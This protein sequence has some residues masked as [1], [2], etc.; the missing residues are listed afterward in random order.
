MD[1]SSSEY[2]GTRQLLVYRPP[3]YDE[4]P[5]PQYDVIYVIDLNPNNAPLYIDQIEYLF[6]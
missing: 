6:N 5:R 3:G 4:N 2:I 1:A